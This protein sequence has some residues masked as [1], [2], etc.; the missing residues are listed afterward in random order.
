MS[1]ESLTKLSKNRI[2][3]TVA[4]TGLSLASQFASHEASFASK[5]NT[6]K[7]VE[8]NNQTTQVTNPS[9]NPVESFADSFAKTREYHVNHVLKGLETKSGGDQV[10]PLVNLGSSLFVPWNSLSPL[11]SPEHFEKGEEIG[12]DPASVL[13]NILARIESVPEVFMREE[14]LEVACMYMLI[15]TSMIL[16]N[17]LGRKLVTGGGWVEKVV[18][19]GGQVVAWPIA[20]VGEVQANYHKSK[21]FPNI[22]KHQNHFP[23]PTNSTK[24]IDYLLFEENNLTPEARTKIKSYWR[25]IRSYIHEVQATKK[26]YEKYNGGFLGLFSSNKSNPELTE[27]ERL[28]EKI[29]DSE[30]FDYGKDDNLPEGWHEMWADIEPTIRALHDKIEWQNIFKSKKPLPEVEKIGVDGINDPEIYES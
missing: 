1:L 17:P 9:K 27:A 29:I 13:G 16:T 10:T 12:N 8:L 23:L 3:Q 18:F 15:M 21:L 5:S 28:I 24:A 14:L 25:Q 4:I 2:A 20:M 11:W 7:A 22:A 30:L 6:E 19:G 26:Q